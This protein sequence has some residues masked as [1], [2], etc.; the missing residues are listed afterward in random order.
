MKHKTFFFLL[1]S[2]TASLFANPRYEA[3]VD[4]D[5]SPYA[6]GEDLVTFHHLLMTGED[7]LVKRPPASKAW[8]RRAGRLLE[9]LTWDIVDTYTMIFQHEV[10]GHGYRIRDIGS[11]YA[12]V[13]GYRFT[14][15]GAETRF[16]LTPK[17]TT[18]LMTTIAMGGVEA[19]AI[20][21]NRTRLK[22]LQRGKIDGRESVLYTQ[23][24][25]DLTNYVL[26]MRDDIL[27]PSLDGH[28]IKSYL[29]FLNLTYEGDLTKKELKQRVLVNFLDPFTYY[30]Y[31]AWAKFLFS[32]KRLSIPMIPIG[33]YR[34]LPSIRM[35]LSPF[36]PEYFVENFLV[37]DKKPIYFYAKGGKYKD[38]V[39]FGFGLEQPSLFTWKGFHMGYRF[40]AWSQ[41]KVLFHSLSFENF[42]EE[43]DT[44]LFLDERDGLG[45]INKRHFGMAFSAILENEISDSGFLLYFEPGFKTAGF[46]PGQALRA[47]PILRG[48]FSM[49]F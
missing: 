15:T 12:E 46:L 4:I 45:N 30:A 14:W 19:T 22:W 49:N 5:F 16:E 13:T 29:F 17:I 35:G 18:S 42:D 23:S 39:Y 3:V 6:G 32:G 33:S 44:V 48:G 27:E 28:D 25:Q 11:K 34:Y 24:Q 36:G 10:F 41:P 43:G 40:D 26:G 7:L 38:N 8:S 1:F 21:A 37:K 47:A 2:Y 31:Y 20:L 9:L